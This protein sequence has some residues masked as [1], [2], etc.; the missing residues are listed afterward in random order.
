MI[1]YDIRSFSGILFPRIDFQGLCI[2]G[3][4]HVVWA[5]CQHETGIETANALGPF[6]DDLKFAHVMLMPLAGC[7]PLGLGGKL[8]ISKVVLRF[9]GFSIITASSLICSIGSTHP[10]NM[11]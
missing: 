2:A 4:R 11:I 6:R 9:F 7:R 5:T 1:H 3:L 10:R 8:I